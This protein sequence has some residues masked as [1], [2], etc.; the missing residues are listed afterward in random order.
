[1]ATNN[2]KWLHSYETRKFDTADGDLETTEYA[3]H[4]KGGYCIRDG[5]KNTKQWLKVDSGYDVS[6]LTKVSIL[7]GQHMYYHEF[8]LPAEGKYREQTT[9]D[10]YWDLSATKGAPQPTKELTDEEISKL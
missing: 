5:K 3:D 4:P 7:V 8:L 10:C 1:M 9:N 2:L 6:G